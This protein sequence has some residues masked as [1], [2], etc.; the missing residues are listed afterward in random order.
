MVLDTSF[1]V[2]YVC[3]QHCF[4]F[5]NQ[6][7]TSAA[8]LV[9][10]CHHSSCLPSAPST[11]SASH[12]PCQTP[13]LRP[14]LDFHPNLPLVHWANHTLFTFLY[15]GSSMNCHSDLKMIPRDD[16]SDPFSNMSL[17]LTCIQI[18]CI[19]QLA[20]ITTSKLQPFP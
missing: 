17:S 10:V 11:S 15:Q 7:L 18:L 8:A 9:N 3:T 1:S 12:P 2:S 14:S 4:L 6:M 20:K 5:S 13:L 16:T 19:L